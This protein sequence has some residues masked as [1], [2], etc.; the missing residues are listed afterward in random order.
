VGL[1]ILLAALGRSP[2]DAGTPGV[3]NARIITYKCKGIEQ[4]TV[5]TGG[6][7][8]ISNLELHDGDLL[9]AIKSRTDPVKYAPS[10]QELA[11]LMLDIAAQGYTL[12]QPK[13]AEEG[14]R[15]SLTSDECR[16]V[17]M[18]VVE[19]S[20]DRSCHLDL[21]VLVDKSFPKRLQFENGD[22]DNHW[23]DLVLMSI[24]EQLIEPRHTPAVGRMAR[25]EPEIVRSLQAS[26]IPHREQLL[27]WRRLTG[28]S[29]RAFY[30][31]QA[32]LNPS[33]DTARAGRR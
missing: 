24:E 22:A 10:D 2:E 7:V 26:G 12:E 23:K 16:E 9:S 27:E 31:W 28:K 4:R 3:E 33:R 15:T 25:P 32:Q 11:A 29:P 6:I 14:K 17:A 8:A 1:Q 5:F 13:M 19:R 21:R 30:R 18:F 20:L